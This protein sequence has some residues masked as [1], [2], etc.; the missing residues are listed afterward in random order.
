MRTRITTTILTALVAL[1]VLVPASALAAGDMPDEIVDPASA[2]A[3]EHQAGEQAAPTP[4]AEVA[5]AKDPAPP[6][7]VEQPQAVA[8][9]A[10]APSYQPT[11]SSSQ[12]LPFTGPAEDALV[13]A[14]L[15]GMLLVAGG[16]TA[17]CY[18]RASHA[19]AS[20]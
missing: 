6:S 5:A 19:N 13:L 3:P 2:I 7:R 16:A 9:A 18:G 20:A 8:G 11:Y 12:Q 4:A 14:L 10:A 15:L 17:W 1:F